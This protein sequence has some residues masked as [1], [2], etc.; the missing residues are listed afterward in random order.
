[1]MLFYD[2]SIKMYLFSIFLY[3]NMYKSWSIRWILNLNTLSCILADWHNENHPFGW[4]MHRS[5][6]QVIFGLYAFL[7]LY[8]MLV[9]IELWFN[10]R[11]SNSELRGVCTSSSQVEHSSWYMYI[12]QLFQN[13]SE[14]NSNALKHFFLR[15]VISET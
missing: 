3:F 15:Y 12:P 6:K 4:N 8:I 9:G 14:S 1:M 13:R 10:A 11:L 5:K 2:L 7:I